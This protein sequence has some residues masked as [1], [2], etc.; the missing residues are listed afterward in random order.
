M[1]LPKNFIFILF[2]FFIYLGAT[3]NEKYA[4]T[5]LTVNFLS[6]TEKVLVNGYPSSMLIDEMAPSQENC[7][8]V[9]ITTSRPFF[10]WIVPGETSYTTQTAFQIFLSD[11][12]QALILDRGS[13][14]NTG[15]VL[16]N[17][18][19]NITYNGDP[20]QEG[21]IYYWKVRIW[22]NHGKVS[23]FSAI[24]QFKT[25]SKLTEHATDRHPIQKQDEYPQTITLS[26]LHTHLVD[27]G[28]AAFGR[29]RI[30]L[31]S[32]CDDDTVTIHLGEAQK[33]GRVLRTPGGT[34]RYSRYRI[35]PGKGWNTYIVTIQP[36]AK[37]TGPQAI[38]M[39]Q[40]IGEVTPF[41][42]C[43]IENYK[44]PLQ[45]TDLIRE[46]A[47]YP[48]D[49][50]DSYFF[51]SDTT[52]N[53]VWDI[54]KYSIK[55]T[56]FMGIYVD[57]DR[58][59]IP[60][61]AD[62][63]INQLSH[64]CVARD[65]S[66]ARYTHEYLMHKPTWPT[67][68]I[69][70]SVLMAWYDYM[71]TGNIHSL[72][73][74][75]ED[76]KAK[77]LFELADEQGFIST[78]TGRITPAVLDAI[79]FSGELRDIVDW[80]HTGILGL[81][82]EEGGETDGFVFTHINTVVNAFHY[83][84]ITLMSRIALLLGKEKDHQIFNEGA[85]RL[86][87]VFNEQLFDKK[88][89]LYI[90]GIGTSHASLHA[91]MFPL[92]FGLVEAENV[93]SVM[94]FIRSRG[95]ACSVYGAQFL[96]D[97]IYN[98]HD[99]DYGLK[100][101]ASD[102]ERSWYNMIRSG[103]TITTE[104]WDNKYKPNQ[105][106]NHAWGAAPANLI[107][108][109]LMGIEPIEP[110]FRKI[111]IKPQPARLK[112]AEI[113]HPTIR[114]DIF[115]KFENQPDES[116][117]LKVSIPANTTADVHLPFYCEEQMVLQ[118]NQEVNFS[119]QDGF[120]MIENVGSGN[121]TFMV[122]RN[123]PKSSIHPVQLSCEYLTDPTGLD[124]THPRLSWKLSANDKTAF[125]QKQSAYRILVG[126]S[127]E[128]LNRNRGDLWDSDWVLSDDMQLIGYRGSLLVSDQTYYW[129]VA[130]KDENGNESDFSEI[131]EWSTGLFEQE[132]WTAQWIG[133]DETYNPEE[134]SNT[135]QDPWF[136]KSFAL[137]E[138]PSKAT[139]F[140]ASVGYHEVYVNGKKIGDHV[141]APAVTDHTQRA[142][143]IAYDIAPALNC[144]NNVI[145]VW[146]GVSWSIFAPYAT[147]DKPRS[148]LLLAQ[149]D[150]Y[151]NNKQKLV[152]IA[153]DSSWKT[154]P[155]PNK[156][157]GNWGFGVGGYGG[158][159]WD[160]GK[161]IDGWNRAD[162]DDSSWKQARL[163]T[164]SLRLSAQRV[165]TNAL[166][167]ELHPVA[168]KSSPDG[169]YRVD[170]G[171][172]YAG[173]TRIR[174]KGNPGDTINLLFSE[175]EQEEMTF[176]LHSSFIVG[177][178]GESV[179]QN[180]FN[181]MSGRW[182]TIK[183]LTTPPRK[184]DIKGWMVRTDFADA[185]SFDCSDSLQNWMYKTIKWT[186]ENL[187]LGGYIV[188]CPQRERLGYGG[189]AHA[190]SET[191]MLNY[192]LGAFYNKWL[193]DWRDVQ[194]TEPMVGNMNDPKWARRQEGS[195]RIM[196][197]GILPQTAPTYHGGGGPAWGGIVVTLPW[198]MYQYYGDTDVL[199]ENF[200]MIKDWLNFLDTHVE[201]NMLK[202]YGGAWDFLGDWLWPGATAQ[203]MNNNS[204]ENLFFNNCYWIYNLRIASQIAT[205]AGRTVEA[206]K[207]RQQAET[208]A[209]TIHEKYYHKDDHSY[210][211][212]S[213]RS[214]A[215]ALYGEIMP[216]ALRLKVMERLEKEI[217]VH[218]KGH[219]DV[220]IT[221]GAMLFKVL[222]DEGR[223]DLI[224]AMTSQQT[225]PSWGFMQKNGATTIWEMWEKDL[226]GH[227]LLHS[228]YLYPGAWYIDGLAGIR[229]DSVIPGFRKFTIRVPNLS[230]TQVSRARV[231]YDSPAGLIRSHWKR[232]TGNVVLTVTVPPNCNAT[233]WFPEEAGKTV[234]EN[235]GLARFVGKQNGYILFDIPAGS[236]QFSNQ[237]SLSLISDTTL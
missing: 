210:S 23:E 109:K 60:Y 121:W 48:F 102:G 92:A 15:K 14:W 2:S 175:R 67:E 46:T 153:T 216:A 150:I 142:R 138:K 27:F 173:W 143:Y 1:Y 43:E 164:P 228:S 148:P 137:D 29:I 96:L 57:G 103:S 42:Y 18:S 116:F 7:Q 9:E 166:M 162:Y 45:K 16:S 5:E 54:S 191:G 63:L 120:S 123:R 53:A 86:K 71:Y 4:P 176:N 233:V 125:G 221:G 209:A 234:H 130:V 227:S 107:P 106:W 44:H 171:V 12:K 230:E 124:V 105:D 118:N 76:L 174:L 21:K 26:K 229:K 218:R 58:E 165:E 180:R 184:E 82:K 97:A 212:R 70:Q 117:L 203:G 220:G 49:D 65:Y 223:D 122:V 168:I 135:M 62:A 85:E 127:I 91:N 204:D 207:W 147:S 80:P 108:R 160:A 236:Y 56:S 20:L 215:A 154:L 31:Y 64:Y 196:G 68:W 10:G 32:D 39:P 133:T 202:R 87:R 34:I 200:E 93:T 50:A 136:R 192:E 83:R 163:Y 112:F 179:F 156:L 126:S 38:L 187:S 66:M 219:I 115:V 69:L 88:R 183:G 99:A 128:A 110:G 144:G 195:G 172:N 139:L 59:R 41:R 35:I 52:L 33:D 188:D 78:R 169:S 182:I 151:G 111:R 206:W 211:D 146:L 197:G 225:Y 177:K 51:S 178:S 185:T 94:D 226:P 145:A 181:Y 98:G 40:H 13:L 17:K 141:L 77:T 75:Y 199:K 167:E 113:K 140:V 194:G 152:R 74:F 170:M 8:T 129:K 61:E 22:D 95:M 222:R 47:L 28:K 81:E 24:S 132:E 90:D 237:S 134:K 208:A 158:E 189:D 214:L 224:Y 79:H 235:S 101:L 213:M 114:G 155:S 217:L 36:D 193:E 25:G 231:E 11:N 100:L 19:S 30:N 205:V 37:N 73:Y 186:F 119:Q 89:G 6:G 72:S 131:A 161:E 232:E 159:I 3:A 55:A 201:N 157:I 104:A 149:T 198:F 84:A 190:T